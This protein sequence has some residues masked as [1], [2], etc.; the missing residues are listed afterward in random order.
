MDSN[1]FNFRHYDIENFAMYV[2]GRQIPSE[3]VNLLMDHE[4]KAIMGYRTLFEG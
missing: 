3:G 1:P 2:N 4:K